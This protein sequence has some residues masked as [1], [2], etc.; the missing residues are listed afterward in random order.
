MVRLKGVD[1][2][3]ERLGEVQCAYF[4]MM[5]WNLCIMFDLV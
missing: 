2:A 1:E 5:S 4:S 3:I